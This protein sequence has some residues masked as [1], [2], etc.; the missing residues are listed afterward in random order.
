VGNV[1]VGVGHDDDLAVA[2]LG[3]SLF[4]AMP[5]P[6]AAIMLRTSRGQHLSSRIL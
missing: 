3:M 6:M 1:D 4:V 2:A 5:E